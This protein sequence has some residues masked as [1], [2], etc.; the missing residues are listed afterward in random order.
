MQWVSAPEMI[1]R[2]QELGNNKMKK[3]ALLTAIFVTAACPLMAKPYQGHQ[4]AQSA[5]Q[6]RGIRKSGG[7]PPT[8]RQGL[9]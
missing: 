8:A 4:H 5:Q 7:K 1:N 6:I 3:T 2:Q 9:D